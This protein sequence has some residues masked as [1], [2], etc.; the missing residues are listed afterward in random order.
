MEY[1]FILLLA[2]PAGITSLAPEFG[3]KIVDLL[4]GSVSTFAIYVA[5]MVFFCIC[6]AIKCNENKKAAKQRQRDW[7]LRNIEKTKLITVNGKGSKSYTT[8]EGALGRAALGT[9]IA[10]PIGGI[11]GASTASTRTTT[12]NDPA[13]YMFMV[14]L[15]NGTR[16]RDTVTEKS[17]K[18]EI[19][20]DYLDLGD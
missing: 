14:Y 4:G 10:G 17:W 5:I 18:F 7:L 8:T 6:W 12:T 1:I 13:K 15:K 19:Y 3:K 11:I 2:I 16:E 9:M 20:M